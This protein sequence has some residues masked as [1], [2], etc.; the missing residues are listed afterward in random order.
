M[1]KIDFER[2]IMNLNLRKKINRVRAM[3]AHFKRVPKIFNGLNQPG[4]E[5]GGQSKSKFVKVLDFLYIFF[6]LKIMPNNYYLFR[7][8]RKDRSEFKKYLGDAT[9][10][11]Y[12]NQ[13]RSNFWANNIIVHDKYLFK[14][15]CRCHDLP[16]AR[17]YGIIRNE[18]INENDISIDDFLLKHEL[19]KVIVKPVLGGGGKGIHLITT[20]N[21]ISIKQLAELDAD[22]ERFMKEGYL[23]EEAL[24]QHAELNRI[25]PYTLNSIRI[26]TMLCPNGDVAL[27]AA[28]LKTNSNKAAMDNFS[29]GGIV[30]GLDPDTGKLKEDGI[31]QHPQGK[32]FK[33]HPLTQTVFL[34]FQMPFW[35]TVKEIALKA[36]NVFHHVK[37]V[38][39]D[40]AITPKGPVIIEGN[41]TWG[42]NGIQAANGGLLTPENKALF[43]SH[44]ITFY[45]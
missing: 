1:A 43:A 31:M 37:S 19:E 35:K 16:V 30:I 4:Y 2:L 28:M 20:E 27:L 36:Q 39:W 14:C 42:T 11:T 24:N 34:D 6:I 7:F 12:F 41:Q 3:V 26:V 44:G 32:V 5:E 13:L 8:D 25:N 45:N 29:Q 38:G 10:P 40:V 18:K 15:L 33:R 23:I 17:H 21:P 22:S 9:E